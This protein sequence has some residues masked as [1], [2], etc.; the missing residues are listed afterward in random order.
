[1]HYS[2]VDRG[3]MLP[4][5]WR[6]AVIC[7]VAPVCI[8]A[9]HA[10]PVPDWWSD[11]ATQIIDPQ[12]SPENYAPVNLGQLKHVASQARIHLNLALPQW[13]GAGSGI[14]LL[15]SGFS[16]TD[17]FAPANLGQLKAIAKPFY[18]RIS[19]LGYDTRANLVN[20]GYPAEWLHPYPWAPSTPASE[21]YAA[22]NLGQLKV[23]FSFDL[24]GFTVVDVDGDGIPDAWELY[25][26]GTLGLSDADDPDHDGLTNLQ[27]FLAGSDPFNPDTDGD[28]FLDG[29][30][31]D[32]LDPQTT[33]PPANPADTTAPIITILKP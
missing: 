15:V 5:V 22:A 14:N 21:N 3:F 7:I 20:R 4:P 28:G 13:G 17:N 29:A 1:M 24:E 12:A 19:L 8:G 10:Q 9:A 33:L 2:L 11:S 23:V 18:D 32:P 6:T 26:F 31:Y 25:Y 30:D 16:Q 27:E